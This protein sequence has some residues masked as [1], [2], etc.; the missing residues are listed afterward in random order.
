[1]CFLMT[2]RITCIFFQSQTILNLFHFSKTKN[3]LILNF[4]G[5]LKIFNVIMIEM[6]L[7][8]NILKIVKQTE[9]SFISLVLTR[10]HKIVSSKKYVSLIIS[11]VL[12]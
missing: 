3:I 6:L 10:P 12:Y 4:N 2:I 11:F 9:F 7:V 5:K 8:I 1:M